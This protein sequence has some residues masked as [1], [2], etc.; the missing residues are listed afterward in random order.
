MCVSV[1][2]RKI[3][4]QK[5]NPKHNFGCVCFNRPRSKERDREGTSLSISSAG[6]WVLFVFSLCVS[7][8]GIKGA[9]F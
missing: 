6:L 9:Y 3:I 4:Y 7:F 1:S 5:K 8:G 2:V